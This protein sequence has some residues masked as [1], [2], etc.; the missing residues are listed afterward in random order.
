MRSKIETRSS[1]ESDSSDK[2][3]SVVIPTYKRYAYLDLTLKSIL[4][5]THGNLEVLVVADGDDGETKEIVEN[6]K[7]PRAR[8]LYVNHAGFPAVPRNKGLRQ[9]KGDLLAFCD[10]DDLWYPT[11][12]WPNRLENFFS[13]EGIYLQCGWIVYP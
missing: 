1:V 9:A 3:V 6:Q 2:L 7:D 8:Y 10:D 11:K 5:Q 12:L 13:F 4:A